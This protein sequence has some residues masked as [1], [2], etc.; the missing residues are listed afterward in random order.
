KL[1]QKVDNNIFSIVKHKT[2]SFGV[3]SLREGVSIESL[4]DNADRALYRSKHE[5]RNRVTTL[6]EQE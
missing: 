1:R 4:T 3:A 6:E 2:A 5:G